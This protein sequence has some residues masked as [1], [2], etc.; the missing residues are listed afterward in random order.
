MRNVNKQERCR[1]DQAE[2]LDIVGELH[3]LVAKTPDINLA[4][5]KISNLLSNCELGASILHIFP[6]PKKTC[7][8][9]Q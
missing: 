6:L 9:I 2:K 8:T 3:N 4:K 5:K 7:I 1:L